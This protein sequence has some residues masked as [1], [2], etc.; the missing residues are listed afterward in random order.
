[1]NE[2]IEQDYYGVVIF[3]GDEDLS[4]IKSGVSIYDIVPDLDE[5]KER[6]EEEAISKK[7][8]EKKKIELNEEVLAKIDQNIRKLENAKNT[9]PD[10]VKQ[11]DKRISNL[12]EI[13]SITE[14]EIETSQSLIGEEF[15]DYNLVV[16]VEDVYPEYLNEVDQIN[17]LEDDAAKT[18]AIRELNETTV[19]MIEQ[20]IETLE[21]ELEAS[22]SNKKMEL[23]LTKYKE[24]Q[25]E[26]EANPELAAAGNISTTSDS[27]TNNDPA[28]ANDP[29]S[30]DPVEFPVIYEEV[31]I[32]EVLPGYDDRIA[33][34][35][36]SLKPV[37]EIEKDKIALYDDVLNKIDIEIKELETYLRIDSPNKEY[38]EKKKENLLAIRNVVN[39]EKQKSLDT[40]E[41][42]ETPSDLAAD[43]SD[44]M[45]DYETRKEK[46]EY[47]S[48]SDIDKKQR[49]NE[50]NKVLL[51][52][53]DKEKESLKEILKDDP[54][55]AI[56]IEESIEKL[57]ELTEAIQKR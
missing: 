30:T 39:D 5:R 36:N 11:L 7:D 53:I 34:I 19:N 9:H 6:I 35:Q 8:L 37:P 54:S 51:F 40:I 49:T 12:E 42:S 25:A 13:R 50:L 52:E 27:L 4:K 16:E 41:E 31:T 55:N 2:N 26:I 57:D 20:K 21:S 43:I 45:P 48:T 33:A 38:A 47:A 22:G 44:I 17:N 46:I 10:N 56:E 3:D 24:L 15:I 23:L 1:M 32:N 29:N 14:T 28:N 18:E